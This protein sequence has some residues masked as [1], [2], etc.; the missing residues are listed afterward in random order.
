MSASKGNTDE[1]RQAS[2]S[3][4]TRAPSGRTEKDRRK[5]CITK[6]SALRLPAPDVLCANLIKLA[7]VHVTKICAWAIDVG[8]KLA[9][10]SSVAKVAKSRNAKTVQIHLSH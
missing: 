2:H 10:V 3:D 1:L 4:H 6:E 5:L 7:D 9:Q 8:L